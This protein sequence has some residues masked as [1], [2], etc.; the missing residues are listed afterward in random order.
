MICPYHKYTMYLHT[1]IPERYKGI[2]DNVEPIF[3]SSATN[4]ESMGNYDKDKDTHRSEIYYDK[5]LAS[6]M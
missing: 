2:E 4:Y 5:G 6:Y 3:K 1:K